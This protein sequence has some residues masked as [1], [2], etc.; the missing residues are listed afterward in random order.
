MSDEKIYIIII[1][2]NSWRDTI[3]CL[4]SIFKS[5]CSDSKVIVCDNGSNDKS[6]EH[7][8]AWANGTLVAENRAGRI[9]RELMYPPCEK[10]IPFLVHDKKNTGL[11]EDLNTENVS[12]IIIRMNRN[13]GFAGG[14]NVG[15]RYIF[16]RNNQ[17]LKNEYILLLNPDTVIFP[18]ALCSMMNFMK[19]TPSAGACGARLF[20]ADG[21]PQASY[22]CFPTILGML[23][24]LFPVYKL[25]PQRLFKNFKRLCVTPAE[26]TIEPIKV[27]YPSGACLMVRREVLNNIGGMDESFFVYFEETDWC[28]R[29][30]KAGWERYYVPSA[31][32]IHYCGGSF[33]NASLKRRLFSLESRFKFFNKHFSKCANYFIKAMHLLSSLIFLTFWKVVNNI[34]AGK[35]KNRAKEE[36]EYFSKMFNLSLRPSNNRLKD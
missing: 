23:I 16:S 7:I 10:P 27:D 12:L 4:D 24:H 20:Y 26:D 31:R 21:S 33:E 34:G 30:M 14:N 32:V 2:W 29:M 15:I 9:Y 17:A 3:V 13:L 28:Y 5:N 11:E 1:N 19:N 6:L 25:F 8:M 35:L 22:G 18:D 36:V